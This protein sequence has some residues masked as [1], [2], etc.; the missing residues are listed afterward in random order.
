MVISAVKKSQYITKNRRYFSNLDCK[1]VIK[2]GII[3][4][5]SISDLHESRTMNK[6]G[7]KEINY[8]DPVLHNRIQT[9]AVS[10]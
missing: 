2:L 3:P 9:K 1:A 8:T 6:S 10:I 4:K 5:R 7:D